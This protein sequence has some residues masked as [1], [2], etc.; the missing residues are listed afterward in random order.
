MTRIKNSPATKETNYVPRLYR[1]LSELGARQ[2]RE[3]FKA[4]RAEYDDLRAMWLADVDRLM[5][6]IREWWPSLRPATAKGAAY[7]IYRDTRFSLDKSPFKDYFSASFGTYGR[8]AGSAHLPSLYLHMGPD[9]SKGE[10]EGGLYGG[11]WCPDSA[12]LKKIR[13]AIVDNIEE[14]DE[15]ISNPKLNKLYPGWFGGR[16]KTIPKGYDRDHP[17][18]ELLRLKEYGR[19]RACGIDYF[20]DPSWPERAAEDYEPLKPLLDFLTYSLEEEV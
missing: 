16:L 5:L 7:R 1:F 11:M 2:D 20:S 12:A 13:K 15:I 18:A 4:N 9:K 19:F 17:Q 14:F 3:W 6:G 10:I 8:G